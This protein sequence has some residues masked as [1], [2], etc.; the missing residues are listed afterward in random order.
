M[1]GCRGGKATAPCSRIAT[2]VGT[3]H[4]DGLGGAAAPTS[5]A[6]PVGG[7]DAKGNRNYD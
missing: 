3:F 2:A 7:A 5:L 4:A 1:K 6:T